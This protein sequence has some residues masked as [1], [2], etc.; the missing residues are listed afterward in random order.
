MLLWRPW[1]WPLLRADATSLLCN[2]V[3][4]GFMNLL[5]YMSLRT[6]PFGLTVAAITAVPFAVCRLACGMQALPCWTHIFCCLGWVLLPSPVRSR[7]R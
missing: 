7:S 1:R 3:A 5:F 6:I 4:L 2:G